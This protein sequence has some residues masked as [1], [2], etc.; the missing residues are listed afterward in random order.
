MTDISS[1]SGLHL[2]KQCGALQN[3]TEF[4][5]QD[6]WDEVQYKCIQEWIQG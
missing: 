4:T 1:D 5:Q 6:N 3:L 2:V